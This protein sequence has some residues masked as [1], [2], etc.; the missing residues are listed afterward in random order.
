M[1]L[2]ELKTYLN[3][4]PLPE[5]IRI[6]ANGSRYL[7]IDIV[8]SK[9]DYLTNSKWEVTNFSHLYF[10]NAGQLSISGSLELFFNVDS[11]TDDIYSVLILRRLT[12]AATFKLTDYEDNNHYAATLKSLCIVNA[13]SQEYPC[14]G[15]NLNNDID[16]EVKPQAEQFLSIEQQIKQ[17]A[18]KK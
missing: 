6:N 18:S 1:T 4:E 12:G 7:P 17:N 3:T 10:N 11:D 16:A 15:K 2:E 13:L 9:L 5:E 8:R 14:F